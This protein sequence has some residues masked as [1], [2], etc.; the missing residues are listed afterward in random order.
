MQDYVA[1]ISLMLEFSNTEAIDK[2][3]AVNPDKVEL[4]K[5]MC[6]HLYCHSD[7]VAFVLGVKEHIIIIRFNPEHG[8]CFDEVNFSARSQH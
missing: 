8:W 6:S 1:F 2:S 3:R 7:L 5:Q 4:L